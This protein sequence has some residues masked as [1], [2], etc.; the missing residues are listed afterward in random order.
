MGLP[1]PRPSV[2]GREPAVRCPRRCA[3]TKLTTFS[4]FAIMLAI[5]FI[6]VLGCFTQGQIGGFLFGLG[7][8]GT[9]AYCELVPA[10]RP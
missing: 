9:V 10:P 3:T 4:W 2:V 8:A 6:G 5:A 7:T 1:S